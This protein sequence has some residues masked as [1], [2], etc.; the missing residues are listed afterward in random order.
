LTIEGEKSLFEKVFKV[1]LTLE[2]KGR[3][4]RIE[5]RSDKQLGYCHQYVQK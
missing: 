5:V 2:K 4:S 1:K 3:T